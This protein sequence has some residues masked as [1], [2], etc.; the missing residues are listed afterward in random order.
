[1]YAMQ[2]DAS[3][4]VVKLL[5]DSGARASINASDPFVCAYKRVCDA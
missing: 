1:M 4:E 2:N 3:V 5:L